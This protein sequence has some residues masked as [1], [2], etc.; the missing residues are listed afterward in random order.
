MDDGTYSVTLTVTD[1]DGAT[2]TASHNVTVSN[3]SPSADFSWL[4]ASPVENENVNFTD[5]SSDPDGSIASWSWTFQDGSPATSTAENPT[6]QFTS[7]GTKDVTLTVTDDDGATASITKQVTVVANQAPT[8]DFTWLPASPETNQNVTFTDNS[9]DTDGTVVAWSWTFQDGNPATSTAQNPTVQFTSSGIKDVTLTVTDDDG[10]TGSVTYQITVQ[11]PADTTPPEL[12]V[13]HVKIKGTATDNV[14]VDDV[15]AT[16]GA[17][18]VLG[19]TSGLGSPSVQWE[20]QDVP[21]G[22]V[23]SPGVGNVTITVGATD[24]SANSSSVDVQV[25]EGP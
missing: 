16:S 15:T 4:P 24:S 23:S 1:D 18:D 21:L 12:D 10:A 22:N 3:R 7:A 11:D 19:T 20:T 14:Q 2:A 9:S 5:G 13:T 25:T 8:A 6:V 17:G